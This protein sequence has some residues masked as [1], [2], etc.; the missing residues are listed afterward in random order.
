MQDPP[1]AAPPH[2]SHLARWSSRQRGQLL[3]T[4]EPG[5]AAA[6]YP[7]PQATY[8]P[9]PELL[10]DTGWLAFPGAEWEEEPSGQWST[11]VFTFA[12]PG[13]P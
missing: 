12:S 3:I 6:C 10:W 1:G 4:A 8:R 2:G 13:R 5:Q 7:I 9:G 11:P